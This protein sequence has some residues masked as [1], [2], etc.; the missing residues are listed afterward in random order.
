LARVVVSIAAAA[1]MGVGCLE[2]QARSADCTEEAKRSARLAA[3]IREEWPLRSED[4]VT[5]L[6]RSVMERLAAT[7]TPRSWR[8]EV[9][10]NRSAEAY[11]IGGGRIYVSDGTLRAAKSESEL[12]AVLAHEMSH[13]ALGHFCARSAYPESRW[14]QKPPLWGRD[15]TVGSVSLRVDPA[16][17][18]AADRFALGMLERAGYD[19][20]ASLRIA[21]RV[22]LA[23]PRGHLDEMGRVQRLE[24]L[25]A[26]TRPVEAYQSASF[27][28]VRGALLAE[29][30]L[31]SR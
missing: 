26:E 27:G 14:W 8:L 19:P 25:L 31:N 11:S 6:V 29:R 28:R 15:T 24:G 9:V 23:A 13:Q 4:E 2:G 7:E 21:R 3:K 18:L 5:R 22:K 12:A 10:R 20:L 1:L 30:G 16:K 17:E